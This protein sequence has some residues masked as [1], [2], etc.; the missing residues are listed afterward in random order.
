MRH[1]ASYARPHDRYRHRSP[2]RRS[3]G[4]RCRRSA[5]SSRSIPGPRSQELLARKAAAV[6]AGVGHTAP[7]E[8]VA[9]GGGVVVDADGNSL[10][11][12]GSGIAV[13]TL[14]N[15]HPK[16]VEAVQAQVAQFTH[17]CFMISPYESYVAVAEALNRITPGDHA[18]KSALFN[19]GAEAVENAV[20]IA[21]KY[22]KQA[23]RRRVRPRLPRPH[24]PHDGADRQVDAV[25]ER[26]RT[27]SP[28]RSTAHRCRTPTATA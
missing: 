7:I 14:G 1:P 22:T 21:R 5:A 9:A 10:I 18:K 11:D 27:R 17:T 25:Q 15:A 8:A 23:G 24:Q 16:V 20:K 6:A 13:T 28:P 26:V 4:R 3:A 12:L 2:H 19:S